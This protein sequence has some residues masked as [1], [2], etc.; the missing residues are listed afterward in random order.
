MPAGVRLPYKIAGA[1]RALAPERAW[2]NLD[3]PEYEPLY[4]ARLDALGV[5]AIRRSIAALA[6]DRE[7][8]LLCFESLIDGS[9]CHRRIFAAWWQEQ[10]GQP[11]P[12][13]TALSVQKPCQ[14]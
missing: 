8:V 9:W 5:P 4:R 10:T 3:R 12:E 7:P 2:L 11:V 14:Y 1:I 6:L 13:L